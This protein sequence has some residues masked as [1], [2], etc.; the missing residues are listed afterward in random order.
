MKSD[1]ILVEEV[2]QGQVASFSALVSRHQRA[3]LRLAMRIVRDLELAEDIVQESF[4]K[5]YTKIDRFEGRST[6][7]SWIFQITINT[8]KN[9]LRGK[10][11]EHV[12]IGKVSIPVSAKAESGVEQADY[13]KLLRDKVEN[14]PEKQRLALSL[15]I[16]EDLSFK[17]IAEIMECPYDT[18]K[19][20]YR[21]ALLKLR[22]NV[23]EDQRLK[24]WNEIEWKDQSSFCLEAE[25]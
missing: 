10:R 9:K 3:L 11:Y 24:G 25:A 17:E 19:A 14:L 7:K 16:F 5:A 12:D 1:H 15:R 22:H 4:M 13:Q 23:E 21:H 6:F 18:A 20:N 8:A 2:Q